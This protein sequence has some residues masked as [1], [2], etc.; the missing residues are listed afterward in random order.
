MPGQ[1][2]WR[3]GRQV[4]L[5]GAA[6]FAMSGCGSAVNVLGGEDAFYDVTVSLSNVHKDGFGS[7]KDSQGRDSTV[8][9]ADTVHILLPGESWPCCRLAVG[10]NRTVTFTVREGEDYIVRACN[11]VQ[12]TQGCGQVI[13]RV[14]PTAVPRLASGNGLLIVTH[15]DRGTLPR[16]AF[17]GCSGDWFLKP[18]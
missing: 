10:A 12:S 16:G 14:D 18:V 1:A 8:V 17:I 15:D 13:C 3:Y 2:I 9:I 7:I 4:T 6:A 11:K 5:L